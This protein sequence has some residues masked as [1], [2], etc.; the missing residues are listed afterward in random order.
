MARTRKLFAALTRRGRHQVLCGDLAFAGLAGTV[1]TPAS[2]FNLPG[3]AFGHDWLTDVDHYLKTL[4]HLASWGIVAAA[5]N[6]ERGVAP[7]VLNLAFDLGTTLDIITGVRLGP[8]QI[9]VHP[10]KLGVAGHG[11]GGSAAVFAAAGLSGAG[12][13]A[14]KAVA[15]LFPSVTKP[16]AKEAAASLKTPGLVLSAPDDA[17][18]LRTDALDLAGAWQGSVLR[19]VSKAESAGLAEKRRFAAALGLP[20]SDRR[21]QKTARALLTGFLLYHLTGDKD[22]KEF[23]DPETVLPKT[24][25]LDPE[26]PRVTP[27]EQIVALLK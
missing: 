18:S 19:I 21:T 2:G 20:G 7:S 14:P 13:G 22:Y 6:T 4:E 11:V 25:A 16:A 9:S 12:A 15:A 10:T 23:A 24:E 5:P 1:Y 3:V 8:G 26:A 27:E 17:Q